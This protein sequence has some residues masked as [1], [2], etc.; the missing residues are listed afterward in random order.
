MLATPAGESVPVFGA[1]EQA[2]TA[3]GHAA[4]YGRWRAR[5]PDVEPQRDDVDTDAAR[6][7]VDG[8][9]AATPDGRWLTPHEV[10]AVLRA[11]GVPVARAEV[12][13]TIDEARTAARRIGYPVALK[14]DGPEILHKTDV[15]G[16]ALGLR[17]ARAVERAWESMR[18]SVGA[19]MTGAVVQEMAEPGVELIAG[20]VRDDTFGPLVLAGMGGTMAELI[21]DR[22]VRVAPVTDAEADDA[23]RSLRCAPLLTGY[24]GSVPVDVTGVVDVVVRLGLLARDVPQ[25]RELDCNPLIAGPGGVVVVDA[26][27]RVAP[28]DAQAL[29]AAGI[30]SLPSPRPS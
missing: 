25:L 15:G 22:V 27:I 8:I 13:S 17:S 18:A 10:A 2:V 11:Y 9:L 16:V 1:I 23:V 7:L 14:A 28:A 21:G 29:Q 24:R 3:M 20:V 5:P 19:A 26:R 4:A 6:A 12:A 30:R